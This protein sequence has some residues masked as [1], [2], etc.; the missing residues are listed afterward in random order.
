MAFW[1]FGIKVSRV[2][3]E[4]DKWQDMAGCKNLTEEKQ[5][6]NCG[7]YGEKNRIIN[8][9]CWLPNETLGIKNFHLEM[10]IHDQNFDFQ[11][12]AGIFL[13]PSHRRGGDRLLDGPRG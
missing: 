3:P 6:N 2:F 10:F 11:V 4:D 9:L 8:L 12:N 1:R 5:R 13:G 7:F